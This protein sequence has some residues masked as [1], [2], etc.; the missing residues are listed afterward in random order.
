MLISLNFFFSIVL[1]ATS[2]RH[3]AITRQRLFIMATFG[4][5]P[6][7][8]Q[9]RFSIETIKRSRS[10]LTTSALSGKDARNFYENLVKDDH[11][12]VNGLNIRD[13]QEDSRRDKNKHRKPEHRIRSRRRVR[14]QTDAPG[15]R[16]TDNRTET[17]QTERSRELMGLRF[18]HCAHEGNISGLKDLLSKGVDINFQVQSLPFHLATVFRWSQPLYTNSNCLTG[19]FLLDSDDVCQLVW[20]DRCGPAAPAAWSRLGRRGRYAGQRR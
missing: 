16:G 7:T 6:A 15:Q 11:M 17:G 9:E 1:S 19:H 12:S 18:L 10:I 4:F 8:E 13:D 20:T 3:G 2:V 14:G 5:T